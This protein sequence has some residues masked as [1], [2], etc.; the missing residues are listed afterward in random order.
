LKPVAKENPDG[1]HKI[2][3]KRGKVMRN[4]IAGAGFAARCSKWVLAFVLC[5]L[6][7]AMFGCTCYDQPGETLAEGRRRHIRTNRI[8]SQQLMQDLD[9][10]LLLDRPSKLTDKKIR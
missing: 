5:L 4:S 7:V 10:A 1:L 8:R 3:Y 9:A 6:T 2:G